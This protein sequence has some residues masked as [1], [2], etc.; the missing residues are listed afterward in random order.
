ME[1]VNGTADSNQQQQ[2]Q[3]KKMPGEKKKVHRE[4]SP[5]RPKA[6]VRGWSVGRVKGQCR[7][8]RHGHGH[9]HSPGLKDTRPGASGKAASAGPGAEGARAELR[10]KK[11]PAAAASAAGGKKKKAVARWKSPRAQAHI[12]GLNPGPGRRWAAGA[13]DS[14]SDLSAHTSDSE[15]PALAL[16]LPGPGS[17]SPGSG[18]SDSRLHL[19]NS[20]GFSDFSEEQLPDG[21]GGHEEEMVKEMEELRSDNDYLKVCGWGRAGPVVMDGWGW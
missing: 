14:S 10:G 12:H 9:G 16:T 5:A 2:Q 20:L 18:Q 17:G 7:L 15:A 11:A 8:S 3:Q 1:A 19:S 13:T 21:G 6:G 4:P